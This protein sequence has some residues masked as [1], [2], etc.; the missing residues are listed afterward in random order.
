MEGR[1]VREVRT[2]CPGLLARGVGHL[3]PTHERKMQMKLTKEQ[4][5]EKRE[6]LCKVL[7]AM[8]RQKAKADN[9]KKD[10][11]DDFEKNE[12]AYR[13]GGNH[14]YFFISF[15]TRFFVSSSGAMTTPRSS[16]GAQLFVQVV[17]RNAASNESWSGRTSSVVPARPSGPFE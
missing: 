10:L 8:N 5:T 6:V 13:G 4:I 16:A 1:D 9:I 12:K 15:W 11:A 2:R 14:S 7:V 3:A 17:S